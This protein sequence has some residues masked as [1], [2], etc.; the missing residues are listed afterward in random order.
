[1]STRVC[2]RQALAMPVNS[3]NQCGANV[4]REAGDARECNYARECMFQKKKK[5]N[6]GAYTSGVV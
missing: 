3:N 6:K 4:P 1:V 2:S 5:R